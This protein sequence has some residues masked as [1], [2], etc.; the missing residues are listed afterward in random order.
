MNKKIVFTHPDF[1]FLYTET[2]KRAENTELYFLRIRVIR[3][4]FSRP[5]Q[6][7]K[8]F[9]TECRSDRKEKMEGKM[10]YALDGYCGLYCGACPMLLGTKAGTE[11]NACLGCNSDKNP[12]WC[13]TCERKACARE[14]SLEFCSVCADYPCEI[15]ENFKTSAEYP[16]HS[17]VY[18]YL[19]LIRQEGKPAW[20][21]KMKVRWSCPEC[22]QEASWWDVSCTHCGAKLSGYQKPEVG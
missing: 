11:K 21:E 10:E 5:E 6:I 4:R 8:I 20:P 22:Q 12:E 2:P 7:Q 13:V 9:I 16:Y 19:P 17:E 3:V 14:R 15:L 1:S 18:E